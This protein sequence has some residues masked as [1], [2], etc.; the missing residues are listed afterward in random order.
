MEVNFND[1]IAIVTGANSGLEL[2]TSYEL[3]K[4]GA[5]VYMV[6]RDINQGLTAIEELKSRSDSI[7]DRL[8]LHNQFTK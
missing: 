6:C 7:A 1:Q 5:K 2:E 3:A 8:I 4:R